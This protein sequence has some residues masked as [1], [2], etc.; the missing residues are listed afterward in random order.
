MK[1]SPSGCIGEHTHV[2]VGYTLVRGI[3]DGEPIA[4][5]RFVVGGHE[6][7][8]PKFSSF[9][10][11]LSNGSSNESRCFYFTQTERGAVLQRTTFPTT[12]P[13]PPSRPSSSPPLLR[14]LPLDEE[15]LRTM[16]TPLVKCRPWPS[17]LP[18]LLSSKGA[19]QR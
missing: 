16:E 15:L 10:H 9:V 2:V 13:P 19:T 6:W 17:L 11:A 5:E 18:P 1:V 4:S 14:V 3:G 12:R 8:S 7:V